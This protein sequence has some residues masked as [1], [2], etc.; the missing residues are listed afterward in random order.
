MTDL[1]ASTVGTLLLFLSAPFICGWVAVKLKLPALVGYLM[2]GIFLGIFVHDQAGELI[3]SQLAT[4]GVILLLFSVGLELDV[5]Q[6]KRYKRFIFIA[7]LLQIS[8]SAFCIFIFSFLLRFGLIPSLIIGFSCALSSTA[9]VAKIIQERGEEHSL[10]GGMILGILL[11]QDIIA[12][13]LLIIV[14]SISKQVGPW[15]SLIYAIMSLIKLAIVFI[16]IYIVGKRAVPFIFGKLAK[17]SRELLNLLTLIFIL[18]AVMIFSFLKLPATVAAFL[19]GVL[20]A[21]TMEHYHIFSQMRP[22]RDVFSILFFAFLG[23]QVDFAVVLAQ[24]P[25]IIVFTIFLLLTKIIV[26]CIVFIALRLH[27]RTAFSA[28]LLLFQTGEFAF[29]ILHQ[30]VNSATIPNEIYMVVLSVVLISI[31]VT[32]ILAFNKDK[33]YFS[34]KKMLLRRVPS[35]YAF[36]ESRDREPA[37]LHV[38]ESVNHVVICGYGRLGG[39]IG[40]ALHLAGI[41]FIAIDYN[42]Y[43][44]LRAKKNGVA[45]IYGDPT[46]IDVLDYANTEKAKVLITAL[47]DTFSQEAIIIH[48]RR[49]NRDI[50]IFARAHQEVHQRRMKDLGAH[51]V[52]QPEFEAALSI[53][54]KILL[55]F[56]IPRDTIVGKI[57]RLKLEHGMM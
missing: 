13:P 35:F 40:R 45:I 2:G 55:N 12:I 38:V 56:H 8:I 37:H 57:K 42:I 49:L 4:I 44:V 29:I 39:Y 30:G 53:V 19:S 27:S 16:L 43:T 46:D 9:V 18:G 1:S 54:K 33:F 14:S 7:G 51:M 28:G 6:F 21:Q 3:L 31:A 20:I 48:A 26:V 10:L 47:P 23:S 52:I 50:V 25:L 36:L 11:F 24:F 22:F 32:P 5:S 15:T 34:L 17:T 41:S